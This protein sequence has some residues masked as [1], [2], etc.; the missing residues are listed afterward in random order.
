MRATRRRT[1]PV[2]D[3]THLARSHAPGKSGRILCL[4]PGDGRQV[5]SISKGK[6]GTIC[7]EGRPGR[8]DGVSSSLPLG[9]LGGHPRLR[10]TRYRQGR[11][12]LFTGR[13]VPS[14][15]RAE[16][17]ALR[18]L[19]GARSWAGRRTRDSIQGI[20]QRAFSL[21]LT[22]LRGPGGLPDSQSPGWDGANRTAG[23]IDRPPPKKNIYERALTTASID[24]I[25]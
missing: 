11:L 9:F 19:G 20:F 17:P 13:G 2:P 22:R 5:L 18:S 7:P 15:T 8:K 21:G 14:R 4:Y 24:L 23:G 16:R 25:I 12:Y 6:S 3:R 10:R 1:E